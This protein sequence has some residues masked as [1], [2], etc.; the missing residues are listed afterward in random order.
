MREAALWMKDNS[1]KGDIIFTL[2][3][4]QTSYYSERKVISYSLAKNDSDL[5]NMIREY[6]PKYLTI[7]VFERHPEFVYTYP[8]RHNNTLI[9]V[10]VYTMQTDQGVRPV[11]VVYEID[12]T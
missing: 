1:D 10:K 12:F 9:P 3:H 5:E 8:E 2:S 11:L 6:K 4:P 7:S